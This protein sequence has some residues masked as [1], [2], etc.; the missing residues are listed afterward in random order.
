M[1]NSI[2]ID[3]TVLLTHIGFEEDKK[4][5]SLLDKSLGVD[6]IIGGHSHTLLE[7]PC[8]VNDILIVQAGTGTNQIGRFDIVV[9][10]DNNCID[11][12]EWQI[13][14]IDNDHCSVGRRNRT[15]LTSGIST[16][17]L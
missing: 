6:I 1:Y 7:E 5:A 4:L 8:I 12:Y 11:S 3:F 13:V 16:P 9:D 14:P 15:V 10:T 2:D 17:S